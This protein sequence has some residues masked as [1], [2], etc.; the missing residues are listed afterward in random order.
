MTD[1]KKPRT[2]RELAPGKAIALLKALDQD[3]EELLAVALHAARDKAGAWRDKRR[4]RILS[5]VH[6]TAR[7]GVEVAA[8]A[9]DDEPAAP[10]TTEAADLPRGA[11]EYTPGP[12]ARAARAR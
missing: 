1:P 8:G 3:H 6:E 11:T 2:P 10:T 7:A 5:R 12:A 9:P 4:L